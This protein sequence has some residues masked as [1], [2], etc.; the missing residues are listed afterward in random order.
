MKH[1][2]TTV[3]YRGAD[4]PLDANRRRLA[5]LRGITVPTLAAQGTDWTWIVY[6]NPADPLLDER[7]DAFRSAGVPVIPIQQ[8][9]EDVI[10]WSGPVLTTRIDDDDGFAP[11]AFRLLHK[12]ASRLTTRTALMFPTGFRVYQGR[13]DLVSNARNAWVSIYAPKGDR[14]HVRMEQHRR[15]WR[16]APIVNVDTDPAW[17]WVRHQDTDSGIRR[18][19]RRINDGLRSRFP[20]DWSLVE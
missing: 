15:I 10:D 8:R 2:V 18:A 16:F 4:Y 14:A 6:V 5:L 11:H 7:M 19:R 1:Y 17:L 3:S 12:A 9:P 20:V 13:F